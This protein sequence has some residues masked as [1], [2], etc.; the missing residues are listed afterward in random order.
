MDSSKNVT[1]QKKKHAI[2]NTCVVS[3][4]LSFPLIFFPKKFI[5]N[6][7]FRFCDTVDGKP[8]APPGMSKTFKNPVNNGITY[9]SNLSAFALPPLTTRTTRT[10]RLSFSLLPRCIILALVSLTSG[11]DQVFIRKRGRKKWSINEYN[12]Y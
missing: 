8:P 3:G 7:H 1:P 12:N 4:N 6:N 10:P 5:F 11:R 2:S 9:L